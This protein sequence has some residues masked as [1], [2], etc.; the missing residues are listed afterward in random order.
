MRERHTYSDADRAGETETRE[1]RERKRERHTQKYRYFNFFLIPRVFLLR[2][3]QTMALIESVCL[4]QVVSE[5]CAKNSHVSFSFIV[6]GSLSD[7][8]ADVQR[9]V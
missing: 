4:L 9:S 2:R 1:E 8:T 3:M 7:G 6:G 5:R